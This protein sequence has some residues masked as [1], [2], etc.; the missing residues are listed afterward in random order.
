MNFIKNVIFILAIFLLSSFSVA[1]QDKDSE[2]MSFTIEFRVNTDQIIKN[3]NYYNYITDIVPAIRSKKVLVDRIL[4]I[5]SASP[6][7]NVQNNVRLADMRA[8]KIYSYISNIVPREKIVKNN[9]YS[10][11]L[12]K[13]GLDESD[14]QKL[15]A[16]YVEIHFH[17][18]EPEELPNKP[19]PSRKDTV[20]TQVINN[21]YNTYNYY[22]TDHTN[23]TTDYVNNTTDYANDIHVKPVFAV[24]NDLLSDMLLRANIGAE[25]YFNRM[26]FFVEGSFSKWKITGREYDTDSWHIGIRKYFNNNYDKLFIEAFGNAG[27]FDTELFTDVGKIGVFYGGGLGVGWAFSLWP[28]WKI[29]PIIRFGLFERSYYADYFYSEQG[30]MNVVFGEYQNGKINSGTNNEQIS[31]DEPKVI[32]ISKTINKEFFENSYKAFY[33]GPTYVGI[34]IKRDF[35]INKK[36]FKK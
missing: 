32:A 22:T 27:Y 14:Y 18:P 13:T 2:V 33:I 9:D 25:V 12:E 16:T 20:V 29:C 21:V 5:G 31:N 24:Y 36:H 7:G 10:L 6:E 34:T 26:S 8:G 11:F 19:E 17:R 1:S 30:R 28:H 3:D 4:L 15:R 35:C 23:N